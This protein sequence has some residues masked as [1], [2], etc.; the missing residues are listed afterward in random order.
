VAMV[1]CLLKH[2]ANFDYQDEL[3]R[4]LVQL[5]VS[6]GMCIGIVIV[7]KNVVV[8]W[9]FILILLISGPRK[10]INFTFCYCNGL[11]CRV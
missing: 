11:R 2:G 3:V 8:A 9:L 10:P 1:E 6:K 5:P 4:M 7:I